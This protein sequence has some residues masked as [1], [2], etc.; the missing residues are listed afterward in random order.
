MAMLIEELR[1]PATAHHRLAC[2]RDGKRAASPQCD[3]TEVLPSKLLKGLQ[4]SLTGQRVTLA[5][6][7][8]VRNMSVCS[9]GKR[10]RTL[11]PSAG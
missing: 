8:D 2:A 11:A 10:R 7:D 9:Y 3:V 5:G 1:W 4:H 6:E